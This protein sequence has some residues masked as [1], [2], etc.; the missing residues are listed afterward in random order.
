MTTPDIVTLMYGDRY[1]AAI[2]AIE[3]ILVLSGLLL[4]VNGIAAFQTVVDRQ[5][6]RVRITGITLFANVALGTIL[7]PRYALV[8]AI[9]SYAGARIIELAITI[10]YLQRTTGSLLPAGRMARLLGVGVIATTGAW[11]AMMVTS[12]H[13]GFIL[14]S[15]VFVL[16]YVPAS[17]QV[18]YWTDADFELITSLTGHLGPPGRLLVRGLNHLQNMRMKSS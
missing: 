1:T 12:S 14:G 11:L 8:G 13:Y 3:A 17:V 4:V 18:H 5:G 10:F 15:M 9:L 2:P 6:D 16:I 7:I